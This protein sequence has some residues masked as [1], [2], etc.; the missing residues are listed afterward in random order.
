[1][2]IL[3]LLGYVGG[4]RKPLPDFCQGDHKALWNEIVGAMNLKRQQFNSDM[5]KRLT[6]KMLCKY[7][8]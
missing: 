4:N 6:T 8:I 5:I 2:K 7:I 3:S 1:M